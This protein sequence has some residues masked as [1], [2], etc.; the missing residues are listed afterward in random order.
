MRYARV[1]TLLLTL[2]VFGSHTQASC[3]TIQNATLNSGAAD[4]NEGWCTS[5]TQP[6][7]CNSGTITAAPSSPL[8]G[9][10]VRAVVL[11][12]EKTEPR[13]VQRWE[14]DPVRRQPVLRTRS[15]KVVS[16]IEDTTLITPGHR[17]DTVVFREVGNVYFIGAPPNDVPTNFLSVLNVTGGTGKFAD[18]S[19]YLHVEGRYTSPMRFQAQIKGELCYGS[20]GMVPRPSSPIPVPFI[21]PGPPP[22]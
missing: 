5:R 22:P 10:M 8:A 7:Y 2:M 3:Y 9:M 17:E 14:Y 11:V 13:I 12:I 6:E 18:A 21:P 16:W 15:E 4:P 20:P 1:T 19:G